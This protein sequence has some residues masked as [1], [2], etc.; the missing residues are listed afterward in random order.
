[1]F[2]GTPATAIAWLEMVDGD[3]HTATSC[4]RS[5][6]RR[7]CSTASTTAS[8]SVQHGRYL[9]EHIPGARYVELPGADHLWWID[10]DDILDEVESFLTGRDRPPRAP[11][12]CS[13]P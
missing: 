9:A 12:A 5:A 13:P 8:C 3:G 1:M 4:P 7:S 6:C 11:T 10:G 2:G